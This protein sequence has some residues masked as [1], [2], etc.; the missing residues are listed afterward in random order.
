M[1][2]L[3]VLLV[4]VLVVQCYDNTT[5]VNDHINLRI[6][7]VDNN[8]ENNVL[9]VRGIGF[10]NDNDAVNMVVGNRTCNNL[11]LC[12]KV[13]QPCDQNHCSHDSVCIMSKDKGA[14]CFMPCSGSNDN[15]CPCNMMCDSVR[16][17][18][19]STDT[20]SLLNLCTPRKLVSED[21]CRDYSTEKIQCNA[22]K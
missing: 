18:S 14:H 15:S 6:I 20:S 4:I 5:I 21:I 3:I 11:E 10:G 7:S 9:V 17:H 2:I 22:N 1:L 19:L 13:C 8:K 16:V 12:S